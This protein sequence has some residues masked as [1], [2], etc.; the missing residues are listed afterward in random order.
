MRTVFMGTPAFA[1]TCLA[2]LA[3]EPFEIV[4]VYTKVDTPK[5]RGH[6]LACSEVKTLA[7]TLGCPIYQPTSFRDPAVIE[8]LR[9]LQPDVIAVV[10]YGKILPQAVLDIPRYGCINIHGS[11]LP[12]LR[13]A[14]PVQWAVLNG[15]T[16]TGVSAMYLSAGMDE[17]DVIDVRR[18][19]IGEQT[20]AGELMDTLAELGAEL[21]CQT[22]HA[23]EAGT[24]TRTPQDPA[25]AS[26]APMLTKALSPI[27]WSRPARAILCQ[28]RGL[29]PWPVATA[30][31]GGTN[32]KIYRAERV[33]PSCAGS[34]GTPV[35]LDKRGLTVLCC[36]GALRVTEL[37]A[38]GGKRM[39]APDYFRGHPIAL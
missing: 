2:R 4:G 38:E 14:A 19:P 15:L 24:A 16:E 10:A 7:L 27:D 23:I 29:D 25:L 35:A 34:P 36:D 9:T 21:L 28:I 1:A 17:G 26:Y 8:E 5:N 37:Q 22:L 12:A 31:L 11:L 13:G 20:T 6:K 39:K 33:E 18:C 30:T 32:F 3:K